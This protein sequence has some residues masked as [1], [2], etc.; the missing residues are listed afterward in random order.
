MPKGQGVINIKG[1]E[2]LTVARRVND[3]RSD[4]KF[5]GWSLIT[6][7][8]NSDDKVV[9]MVCSILDP[10]GKRIATGHAEEVRASSQINRTSA[11]ENCET[12]AIG[13]ALAS[14]GLGGTEFAS[15]NELENALHQQRQAKALPSLSKECIALREKIIES[16]EVSLARGLTKEAEKFPENEK[17]V[18]RQAYRTRTGG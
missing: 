3:F 8:I 12:S 7:I 14:L 6:Q 17:E 13:R 1:K 4:P 18:I 5:E 9:Q 16:V 15:A 2:Y 10:S 11:L